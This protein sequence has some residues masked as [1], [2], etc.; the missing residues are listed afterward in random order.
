MLVTSTS[1]TWVSWADVCSDSTIRVGD[2]LAQPRDLLGLAAQRRRACAD[3]L[4]AP[5]GGGGGAA[6]AGRRG[7]RGSRRRPAWPAAAA[8]R[9][10][11]LRIRPP[12]PVPVTAA[13][14]TPCWAAI[15]RTSGVTYAGRVAG[16]TGSAGFSSDGACADGAG[17]VSAAGLA[18]CAGSGSGSASGS[19][20][21]SRRR[22]RR[23]PAPARPSSRRSPRPWAAPRGAAWAGASSPE[24]MTASSAPTSTVSSSSTLISSSV[25]ATGRGSRCR[26]CRWRPR[27][28]A[29]R[30]RPRRRPTSASGSRCP[31]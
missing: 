30:P 20:A 8:S 1:M 23:S 12:T 21:A 22:A 11:C 9:T 6:A 7:R 29:R 15:L 25:P 14:S 28:A 16:A 19:G 26:P 18:S 4:G 31:R 5:R 3:G 2:D 10:S 17:A 13:R 24:P 27:A